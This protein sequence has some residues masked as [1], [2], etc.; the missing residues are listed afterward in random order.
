MEAQFA[1]GGEMVRC[2]AC[3][4]ADRTAKKF[5]NEGG[6]PGG[7]LFRMTKSPK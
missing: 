6:E 1:Y 7:L 5:M 2:H 4:A 3:A